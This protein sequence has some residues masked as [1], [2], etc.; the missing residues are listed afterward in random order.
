MLAASESVS[1]SSLSSSSGSLVRPRGGEERADRAERAE[2][3]GEELRAELRGEC[4]AALRSHALCCS[5]PPL[6]VSE[7]A[8]RR[9][10]ALKGW[11]K[12]YAVTEEE[13]GV[14]PGRHWGRQYG[15]VAP[16]PPT[17]CGA[18]VGRCWSNSCAAPLPLA[19]HRAGTAL[20]AAEE[21]VGVEAGCA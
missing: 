14:R 12:A 18:Q 2:T 8:S 5:L 4:P 6:N 19:C 16:I 11:E 21:E 10:V 17:L 3:A 1:S 15:W 7:C 9:G 13:R 20:T